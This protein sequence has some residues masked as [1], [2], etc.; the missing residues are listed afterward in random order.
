MRGWVIFVSAVSS[1]ALAASHACSPDPQVWFVNNSATAS[2]LASAANCSGGAFDVEWVGHVEFPETIYVIDDT[3]MNITG[4][5]AGSIA[6]GAGSKQ[7]LN[8]V[9]ATLR[10]NGLRVQN[11]ATLYSGGA[12]Y[13]VGSAMSFTETTW[14]NNTAGEHGGAIVVVKSSDVSWSGDTTTWSG[15]TAIGGGA[16]SVWESSDVSWSGGNMMWSSNTAQQNGG[17][18]SVWESSDVS[19]SGSNMMWSSNTAQQNGG[20]VSVWESS[21]VSWSGSNMM[22]SSNTAQRNGGA[23]FALAS[24]DVAWSGANMTW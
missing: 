11:C 8:V 20:A 19:W 4:A 9:N 2:D 10:V 15:N 3:V 14:I 12:I 17:A 22:W 1:V 16:I 7:F 21:E 24:S 13:G 6:D 23:V 5:G 18:V